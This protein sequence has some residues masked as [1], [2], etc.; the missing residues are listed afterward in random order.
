M[1]LTARYLAVAALLAVVAHRA[2]SAAL[3]DMDPG[4]VA[5]SAAY[6]AKYGYIS[7]SS[8][9]G[10]TSALRSL[11]NDIAEFQR[12]AGLNVTGELDQATLEKMRQPRCGVKDK[13]GPSTRN[14]RRKRYALQGSRWR[15][16]DIKYKIESWPS[17][18]TDKSAVRE[19]IRKSFQVWADVSSLSFREV[20]PYEKA[21]IVIRF[22]RGDHGDGDPFDGRGGTLAHAFFPLYGGDAHFDDSER[23]SAGD[24]LGTDIFMTASHEFGHSLGLSHSDDQRSLMAPFYKSP[25]RDGGTNV[26]REDDVLG[27]QALYGPAPEAPTPPENRPTTRRP[28][29]KAAS[30]EDPIL[31]ADGAVDAMIT[32]GSQKQ[33]YV[34]KGAHYW[35]LTDTGIEKG[36][37]RLI[38]HYWK[39]VPDDI[40][41]AFSWPQT[42][43]I[44][45]F[46]GNKYWRMTS[47]KMDPGYPKLMSEG[48]RG[49]PFNVDAAFRWTGNG[50][51]YFFKGDQ[52]WK[53]DPS[54]GSEP[55]SSSYP[56]PVSNWGN[57]PG[58]LDA[59]VTYSNGRSYF[60]KKGYYYRFDDARFQVDEADPPYPRP[61]GYWWFGCKS[62]SSS[63]RT[64]LDAGTGM[65][66][67]GVSFSQRRTGAGP[68]ADDDVVMAFGDENVPDQARNTARRPA[69][70]GWRLAAG[71]LLT[72]VLVTA[73]RSEL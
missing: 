25:P 73:A 35:R 15:T 9:D 63:L 39:G 29:Q 65:S 42:N 26:L 27:I 66:R 46:K 40:D 44:Y 3:K 56:Q 47:F 68:S 52:Y 60:F 18:V 21:Q 20:G 2:T 62:Q 36:Y 53:F 11:E 45:F 34:F 49:I 51:I 67:G 38:S 1:E 48:F 41:A 57:L 37:P 12:F 6:L 69:D 13:I 22:A 5:E 50:K 58:N 31:C 14:R 10:R 71:L 70:S 30:G 61:A 55:V 43:R 17:S 24:S 23:W 7:S 16:R 8:G 4:I 33:T 64:G 54:R 59:A 28:L 19:V 32:A 72:A